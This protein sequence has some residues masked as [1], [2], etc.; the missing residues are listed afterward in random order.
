VVDPLSV[1]RQVSS[2]SEAQIIESR[3]REEAGRAQGAPEG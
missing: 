2:A 3:L 1:L